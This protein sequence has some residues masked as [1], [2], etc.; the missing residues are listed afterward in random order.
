[1]SCVR[2]HGES[3]SVHLWLPTTSIAFSIAPVEQVKR[4]LAVGFKAAGEVLLAGRSSLCTRGCGQATTSVQAECV[5]HCKVCD[6]NTIPDWQHGVDYGGKRVC[7]ADMEVLDR[8]MST[9]HHQICPTRRRT[10]RR[11][12]WMTWQPACRSSSSALRC[13][14]RRLRMRRRGAHACWLLADCPH[15]AHACGHP[16]LGV[17]LLEV[18][19]SVC[20]LQRR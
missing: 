15:H 20:A 14:S 9:A 6:G 4:L 13:S 3:C 8:R 19:C 17:P 16:Y 18:L 1:M 5:R 7:L 12:M 2:L 11:M 10:G